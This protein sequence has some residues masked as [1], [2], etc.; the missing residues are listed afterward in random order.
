MSSSP[1]KDGAPLRG[2]PIAVPLSIES[3]TLKQTSARAFD[4]ETIAL[5]SDATRTSGRWIFFIG[6]MLIVPSLF[7]SLLMTLFVGLAFVII[8]PPICHKLTGGRKGH[9]K[10]MRKVL[11]AHHFSA[12]LI[13][14]FLESLN[15]E[16][17]L[18]YR[19]SERVIRRHVTGLLQ[20]ENP[21]DIN[22]ATISELR[23]INGVGPVIARS[24]VLG[25]PYKN[26]D[27]VLGLR[28]IGPAAFK[29]IKDRIQVSARDQIDDL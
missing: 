5:V 18:R 11:E 3:H 17:S 6:W 16:R 24:I 27:E 21:L 29:K 4:D 14:K 28:G 15:N 8:V 23:K 12:A 7:H 1:P 9:F 25:R 26:V 2:A 19:I 13:E 20:L 22:R 10:G